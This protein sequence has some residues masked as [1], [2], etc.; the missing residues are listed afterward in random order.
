MTT[1]VRIRPFTLG[2]HADAVRLWEAVDGMTPLSRSDVERKLR[3]D[4]DLFLVAE[5]EGALV[6]VVVGATDGWTGWV[7]RLAVAP[8][9]RRSGVARG[10]VDELERRF[11]DRDIRRVRLLVLAGN[12]TGRGFWD[13]LGYEHF[14]GIAYYRKDLDGGG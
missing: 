10:L 6:G 5:V 2:D 11:R 13:A 3:R 12:D 1:G 9:A 4:P 7:Y 14:T 8:S